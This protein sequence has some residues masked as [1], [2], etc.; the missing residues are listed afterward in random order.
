MKV[1]AWEIWCKIR[2]LTQRQREVVLAV[3]NEFLRV[4][5]NN[6]NGDTKE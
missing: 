4:I 3:I 1:T 2:R 6:N 5:R